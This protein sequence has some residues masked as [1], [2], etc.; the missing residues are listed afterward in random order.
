[1]A[2]GCWI[3]VIRLEFA[4]RSLIFDFPPLIYLGHVSV[5]RMFQ[6]ISST[7]ANPNILNYSFSLLI[8]ISSE[9]KYTNAV[10]LAVSYFHSLFA[11]RKNVLIAYIIENIHKFQIPICV[12]YDNFIFLYI[13]YN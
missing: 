13:F 2:R 8:F 3:V 9:L 6:V 4:P 12:I 10:Y 7:S 11:F 1:M 5:A